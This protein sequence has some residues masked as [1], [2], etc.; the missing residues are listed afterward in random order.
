MS[1][2]F[3]LVRHAI[4]FELSLYRSLFRWVAR[5][6]THDPHGAEAFGYTKAVTPVMW[7]WIFASACEIPLFHV[8]VPWQTVQIIGLALGSWG[9]MWMVGLLASLH[10]HPHLVGDTALRVRNGAAVDITIA[11]D[12]IASIKYDR[13]D[14][15]SS[16]RA[17]QP[18]ETETGTDL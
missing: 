10:V 11:W 2:A 12:A 17:L 16:M 1:R 4:A 5:R 15:P 3:G 7:L 14:L 13:R 9:L 8:L 18:R 6:Q